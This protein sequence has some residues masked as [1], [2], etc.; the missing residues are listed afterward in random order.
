VQLPVLVDIVSKSPD[1]AAP[2]DAV[3]AADDGPVPTVDPVPVNAASR[4]A[5]NRSRLQRMKDR[6]LFKND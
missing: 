4:G 1:E 5:G 6:G 3:L 2:A